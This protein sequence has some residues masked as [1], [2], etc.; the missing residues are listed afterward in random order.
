MTA[1]DSDLVLAWQ[2]APGV[3]R[4]SRNSAPPSAEDH[5]RWFTAKLA[6]PNCIFNMIHHDGRPAGVLRFDRLAPDRDAFEVSIL[7]APELQGRNIAGAALAQGRRLVPWAEFH[8][9]VLP[10]NAASA[11]LFARSGYSRN[12]LGRFVARPQGDAA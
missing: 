6:D 5:A 4:F 2:C 9:E 3:R 7:V 10:G 1:A 12:V 8:A 11:A